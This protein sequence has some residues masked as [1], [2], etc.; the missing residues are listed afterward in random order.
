M[1][2]YPI[3]SRWR[4]S[5]PHKA[6]PGLVRDCSRGVVQPD[7]LSTREI[8]L[9]ERELGSSVDDQYLAAENTPNHEAV[10]LNGDY[11]VF[12]VVDCHL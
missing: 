7:Q 2:H 11:S 4:K 6:L 9:T 10:T 5:E 8:L 1:P 12:F 3:A